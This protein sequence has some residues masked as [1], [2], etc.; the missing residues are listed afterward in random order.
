MVK[1][2]KQILKRRGGSSTWGVDQ[3]QIQKINTT[4]LN[5]YNRPF[6]GIRFFRITQ[7]NKN[8]SGSFNMALSGIEIYGKP[9]GESWN[10]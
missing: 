2:E 8:S 3:K 1:E 6:E 7:L 5:N 4:F 9:F 10:F